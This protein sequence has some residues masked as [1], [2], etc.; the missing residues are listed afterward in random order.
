MVTPSTSSADRIPYPVHRE[1]IERIVSFANADLSNA[2]HVLS[3]TEWGKD[4]GDVGRLIPNW[5]VPPRRLDSKARPDQKKLI[6]LLDEL[7]THRG[8]TP[9]VEKY[10]DRVLRRMTESNVLY[11]VNG[12]RVLF[13]ATT[14]AQWYCFGIAAL[15]GKGWD[16][17]I[18]RCQFG[19]CQEFF[20]AWLGKRG[21]AGKPRIY[22]CSAHGNIEKQR[23]KR[24]K[25][26]R[27]SAARGIAI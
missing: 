6:W 21:R 13:S 11:S 9:E 8:C 14:I 19:D 15:K 16:D 7:A 25:D 3:L 26:R 4:F 24:K 1:G 2:D 12:V 22:C 5:P 17:L 18:R 10:L 20:I 23:R 27:E